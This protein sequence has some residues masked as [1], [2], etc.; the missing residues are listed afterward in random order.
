MHT[1][2]GFFGCETQFSWNISNISNFLIFTLQG[3]FAEFVYL[4]TFPGKF[5]SLQFS[6]ILVF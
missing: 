6:L 1:I 5:R 2:F 4:W 3:F